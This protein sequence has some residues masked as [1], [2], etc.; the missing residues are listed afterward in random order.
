MTLSELPLTLMHL[1]ENDFERRSLGRRA[2]ETIQS[3]MGATPRTLAALKQLISAE[4]HASPVSAQA[5]HID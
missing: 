3:Q 1:L 4:D 2:Q 5:A